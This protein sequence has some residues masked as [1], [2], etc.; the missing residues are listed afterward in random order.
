MALPSGRT[1]LSALLLFLVGSLAAQTSGIDL[2]KDQPFFEQKLKEYQTWLHSNQLDQYFRADSLIIE[3]DRVTLC[4]EP[5]HHDAS[6]CARTQQTWDMLEK[7][8]LEQ[9]GQYFHERLLHKWAF[10]AEIHVDQAEVYVRCHDPAHFSAHVR[11][12]NGRMPVDG[13]SMR[14][15]QF[16]SV[17]TPTTLDGANTGENKAI[18]P[19]SQV[20][21]V[22]SKARKYLKAYYSKKG[23][24]ILW[25]AQVDDS[26]TFVDE[27]LLEVSHMSYEICPDGFF[28]YHRIYVKGLQQ[29]P[30]VEISWEFQGKYG[31]GI[32]FPPRKNDYKDLDV[33]YKTELEDYQK[34]LFRKLLDYLRK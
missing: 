7:Q 30:N 19:N 12:E 23:T 9:H 13:F 11:S 27:F 5:S 6:V 20:A 34:I 8:N 18:I 17:Q 2:R 29:G 10:L 16:T 1:Y 31:S 3:P 14:T 22:C 15:A 33:R 28:E 25:S 26:Y 21:D 24:P 4:L 32:I